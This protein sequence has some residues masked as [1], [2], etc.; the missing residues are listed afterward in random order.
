MLFVK[1]EQSEQQFYFA[2]QE[3]QMDRDSASRSISDSYLTKK[4]SEEKISGWEKIECAAKG[5]SICW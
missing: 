4:M 1:K 5:Q 3:P 2:K